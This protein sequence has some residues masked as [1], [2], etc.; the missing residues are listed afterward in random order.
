MR[1]RS[2]QRWIP[3]G[4]T[5]FGEPI[6]EVPIRK[7]INTGIDFFHLPGCLPVFYEVA[8]CKASHYQYWGDWQDLPIQEKSFLIAHYLLD[9]L[10]TTHQ[11]D[12][13]IAAMERAANK[14]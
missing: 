14:G 12:A 10:V 1:S 5:R 11:Q 3:F 8:A 7:S 2:Q 9:R 13:E 4:V 6:I